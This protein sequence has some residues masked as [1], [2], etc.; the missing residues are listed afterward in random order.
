M[1]KRKPKKKKTSKGL[2]TNYKSE[3][4]GIYIK[5][6][7]SKE[8]EWARIK[9]EI[10]DPYF[11]EIGLFNVCELNIPNV[12]DGLFIGYAHSRKRGDIAKQEPERTKQLCEVV[13]ACQKCHKKVEFPPRTITE[14]S[15]QIMYRK[16]IEVIDS[17]NQKVKPLDF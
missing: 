12:C 15:R 4:K 13:R 10:L 11:Y 1:I 2:Y 14:S 16:I 9:R 7:E 8:H 17:R 6:K 5:P 3:K